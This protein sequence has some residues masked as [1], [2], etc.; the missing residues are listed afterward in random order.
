[1]RK[2]VSYLLLCA[3]L[4]VCTLPFT[5][6]ASSPTERVIVHFKHKKD[7][8]LVLKNKGKIHREFANVEAMSVSMSTDA[9][10]SLSN[11][12]NVQFIE[13]DTIVH[14]QSQ[15]ADWG[16]ATTKAPQAWSSSYTGKGV[17]IA[18]VDTGIASH[19]DLIIAGGASFVAYTSSYAD[20]NGHGTHVAG[21]IGARNNTVGVVGI[22]PDSTIYAV[23]AL[24]SNGSGYLSDIIAGIDWSITN[25]MDLVNL[26][27]GSPQDSLTLH[28][29]VDKAYNNGILV[30]AAAGNNGTADGSGDTMEYPARYDSAIAVAAIDSNN[31]RGYFSATGSKLEVAAPG[32][33]VRSTY[34]N[35]G[36]A[37]MS[38]TSMATPYVTGNLAL[39]KQANPTLSYTALRSKLDQTVVD[40]GAAGRDTWYGYGLIQAPYGSVAPQPAIAATTTKVSTNK[41]LY[42][43]GE[44]V[45]ITVNVKDA[46]GLAV[47]GASVSINIT[48]PT[49]AVLSG[50]ATTS[51]NGQVV[52]SLGT[53]IYSPTGTYRVKAAAGKTGYTS[54]SASTSFTL[55]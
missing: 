47:T 36:Y 4:A 1:M 49:G 8:D 3:I 46:N 37:T 13:S 19:E 53:S 39:I 6:Q 38:G 20:D 34:L 22:A 12:P 14:V 42:I 33:N 24:D 25:R 55:F 54:S 23:K 15:T 29:V 52:F 16:I 41:S 21:I 18:V 43:T 11:D 2:T 30:V 17:K 9:I 7:K 26:S 50:S 48:T 5:A 35:G 51:T 28:Q 44:Q 40:L 31:Q 27:L 45:L 32:V 10:Q